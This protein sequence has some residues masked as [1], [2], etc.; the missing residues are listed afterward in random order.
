MERIKKNMKFLEILADS[1]PKMRKAI[2]CNTNCEQVRSICDCVLNMLLN[3]IPLN[4]ESKKIL[5][6]KKVFFRKLILNK[7]IGL[8]QKKKLLSQTGTGWMSLLIPAALEVFR[9]LV[10]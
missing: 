6:R 3:R 5:K 4:N 1:K 10:Q 2:L 7:N 8:K 9:N